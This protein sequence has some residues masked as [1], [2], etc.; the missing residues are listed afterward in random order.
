MLSMEEST[1]VFL[2]DNLPVALDCE[3]LS[4]ALDLLY[5]LIEEKGFEPPHYEE[6]NDFGRQAQRAYNDL[7]ISNG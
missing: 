3:V 6:Y 4:D 7:Y 5:N 1:K 2:K